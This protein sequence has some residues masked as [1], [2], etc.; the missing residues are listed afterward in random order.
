MALSY[1]GEDRGIVEAITSK[2]KNRNIKVFFDKF[3]EVVLWGKDL[4]AHLKSVFANKTKFVII[5]ISN[6][7]PKKDWINF[8]FEIASDEVKKRKEEFILPIRIDKTP[9]VG[10][11][12]DISFLE[13]YE[14]SLDEIVDIIVRKV[15]TKKD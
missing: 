15:K 4:G 14:K 8:E 10:F 13:I 12:K 7:F 2:L 1:A 11:K 5:F 6:H 9:L 3:D